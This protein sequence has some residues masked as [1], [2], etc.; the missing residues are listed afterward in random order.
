VVSVWRCF[1]DRCSQVAEFASAQFGTHVCA[2][3]VAHLAG[4]YKDS[5]VVLE[6]SGPGQDVKNELDRL[7]TMMANNIG[8]G[9]SVLENMRGFIYRRTDS[10]GS[11]GSWH[12]K[13]SHD[14]KWL[15]CSELKTAFETKIAIINSGALLDEMKTLQIKDGSLNAAPH[16]KD[17]RVIAACYAIHGWKQ[18]IQP[19]M[20]AEGR[21][22]ERELNP[23]TRQA[24]LPVELSVLNYLKSLNIGVSNG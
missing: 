20:V 10:M 1:A 6:I 15:V 18:S 22:C 24:N 17:D 5:L 23:E 9:S 21:T 14:L 12:L 13:M 11:S 7:K 19:E 16:K 4:Y 2:W 8:A 3:V